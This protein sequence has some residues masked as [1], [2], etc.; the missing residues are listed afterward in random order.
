MKNTA[1]LALVSTLALT[2]CNQSTVT[3]PVAPA[4]QVAYG[5]T[6]TG[7]VATFGLHNPAAGLTSVAINGVASGETLVDIDMRNT[8]TML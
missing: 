4:G 7:K 3:A 2:A 1:L 6:T 8:D 5:L